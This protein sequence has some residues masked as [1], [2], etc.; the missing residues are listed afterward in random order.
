MFRK[1]RTWSVFLP[2]PTLSPVALWYTGHREQGLGRGKC[3]KRL[4][5]T[6]TPP[7]T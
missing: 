7:L 4:G 2:G 1:D 5:L 3:D 6:E